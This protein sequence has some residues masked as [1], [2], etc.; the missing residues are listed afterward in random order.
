MKKIK[1]K[2]KIYK[3][4]KYS[5]ITRD[6]LNKLYIQQEYIARTHVNILHADYIDIY[7]IDADNST[8]YASSN[9]SDNLPIIP[10]Y[11]LKLY[12]DFKNA[13]KP[14]SRQQ[15]YFDQLSIG[16]DDNGSVY[17]VNKNHIKLFQV[18]ENEIDKNENLIL[19]AKQLGIQ[20]GYKKAKSSLF[21]EKLYKRLKERFRKK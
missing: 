12:V 15:K 4:N 17:T 5:F 18:V 16:L 8:V 13:D 1:V 14:T 11:I 21:D 20:E 2:V 9:T 3:T 19:L 7:I 10:N 6:H